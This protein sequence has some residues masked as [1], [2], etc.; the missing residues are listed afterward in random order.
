MPKATKQTK[1][2]K[3]QAEEW[4]SMQ[5]ILKGRLFPWCNSLWTIRNWVQSDIDGRNIL[6]TMVTGEGRGTKYQVK[7]E[8]IIKFIKAVET[9]TVRL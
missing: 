1:P 4:Y 2:A 9:G 8:N 3:V 6:K 7:G 5:D